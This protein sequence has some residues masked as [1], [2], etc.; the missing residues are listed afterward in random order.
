MHASAA[1]K[2]IKIPMLPLSEQLEMVKRLR[3]IEQAK[4]NQRKLAAEVARFHQG[5]VDSTID[6]ALVKSRGWEIRPLRTVCD[7]IYRYP[8]FYGFK[9]AKKG[10]PVLKISNFSEADQFDSDMTRYDYIT[11][12]INR[13]YPKTILHKDDLV[14]GVRGTY[15]GKCVPVPS[16]LEGANMSPNLIRISPDR[17]ILR[18]RFLWHFTCTQWW[19][20]QVASIVHYWKMKFG[21]VRAD[22]LKE[23]QVPLPSLQVQDA[24]LQR[25]ERS[26]AL[27]KQTNTVTRE[28]ERLYSSFLDYWFVPFYS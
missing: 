8:T 9:F 10:V 28:C 19:S 3:V 18:P 6:Y 17:S 22:Q 11:E 4:Q 26:L 7:E 1:L 12:A 21:T 5:V 20:E 24:F 13:R 27:M 16:F 14:M 2:E 25:L 15:I 23:V